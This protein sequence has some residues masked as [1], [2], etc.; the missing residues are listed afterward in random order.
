MQED[1]FILTEED[2]MNTLTI[3]YPDGSS[4][5]LIGKEVAAYEDTSK[6]EQK[7]KPPTKTKRKTKSVE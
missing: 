2:N 3:N 7:K 4:K 5:V 1:L 6:T